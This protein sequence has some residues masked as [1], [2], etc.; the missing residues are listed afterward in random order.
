[1]DD[2]RERVEAVERALTDGDG[3]LVA[4]AEGAAT[5]ERVNDLAADVAAIR[6]D[7]AE[8]S[9]ATQAL[10]GYVGNVRSVNE[11]V[12]ERADAALAS[13]ESLEERVDA[14]ESTGPARPPSGPSGSE[15]RTARDDH[16]GVACGRPTEGAPAADGGNSAVDSAGSPAGTRPDG[17][18]ERRSPPPGRDALDG[19]DQTEGGRRVTVR[20]RS[21]P[22][23]EPAPASPGATDEPT[24]VDRMRELL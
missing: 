23:S 3:E 17:P 22:T 15:T 14:L 19:F 21:A 12:E 13:V 5:A 1:M 24:L 16:E 18:P 2:L 8:V 4:L 7:L 6:E 10:R 11:A 9:A 20:E